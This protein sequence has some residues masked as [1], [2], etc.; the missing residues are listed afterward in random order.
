MKYNDW[1]T[2]E[3]IKL[4]SEATLTPDQAG[5]S[6]RHGPN[7]TAVSIYGT[8]DPLKPKG[9]D[10]SENKHYRLGEEAPQK[11][12]MKLT[13]ETLPMPNINEIAW[14]DV[15]STERKEIAAFL[16]RIG[17]DTGNLPSK[18]E[19]INTVVK[20]GFKKGTAMGTVLSYLVFLKTLTYIIQSFNSAS[21]GFTFES[22]LGVL[23]GGE[24]IPTG[25]D[26][27]ADYMTGEGEYISLKLLTQKGSIGGSGKKSAGS[28]IDGSYTQLIDDLSGT[29]GINSDR[30]K[31]VIALK[32]FEGEGTGL[33]GTIS[34]YEFEI[35][36]ETLQELM[37]QNKESRESFSLMTPKSR[38]MYYEGDREA[39]KED[40]NDFMPIFLSAAHEEG[41]TPEKQALFA[42]WQ[43]AL[44]NAVK[45]SNPEL[46]EITADDVAE[47]AWEMLS[48][49]E[50][51][52]DFDLSNDLLGSLVQKAIKTVWNIQNKNRQ[53][54]AKVDAAL[55]SKLEFMS[56][57]DSAKELGNIKSDEQYY[58]T[59][60]KYSRG[61][62]T[63]GQFKITQ[64]PIMKKAAG[65]R[66]I[67]ELKVG[68]EEVE[69]ALRESVTDVNERM[70]A[71]FNKMNMLATSLQSFFLKGLRDADGDKAIA[72]STGVS[73]DVGDIKKKKK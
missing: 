35:N 57:E 66:W 2:E 48:S 54:K 31:Y 20:E 30:M 32:D 63:T 65:S 64:E 11:K 21:A 56:F 33:G 49:G 69:R 8:A 5:T 38:K 45:K 12:E 44:T 55:K 34:I 40:L 25:Q 4:L 14:S 1:L 61:Y 17:G 28:T 58:N 72:A 42:A 39:T 41:D 19:A 10:E 15:K 60:K 43:K 18:L 36:R 52:R 26:T 9:S 50:L 71:A 70:F 7:G 37:A 67:G 24:Q 6:T 53:T 27:I 23:L 73:K 3:V 13:W 47:E 62:V 22:F 59:I 16:K 68:R 51:E 29:S 46:L